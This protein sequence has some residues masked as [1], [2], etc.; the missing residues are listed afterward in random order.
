MMLL[1]VLCC[2]KAEELNFTILHTSDEHSSLMPA[3]LGDYL[4]GQPCPALGG[5]ARLAT[6]VSRIKEAKASE[7]VLLLSS[8]DFS[9]GTPF[10][11]LTLKGHATELELM[12]KTGYDATTPGNHEFDYGPNGL[13]DYL[14]RHRKLFPKPAILSS[15]IVIPEGHPLAKSDLKRH[16]VINLDN[17]LKIGIFAIL[18]K[19]AHRLAPTAAPLG[20]SDQHTAAHHEIAALKAAGADVIVALT[21]AGYYEDLELATKVAGIHLILGGHDHISLNP[22]ATA[23]KSIIMHSGSYLRSLG[24]LDLAFDR[25]SGKIR[26]RNQQT[27][28]PFLHA[29]DETIAENP[30]IAGN[31][32]QYFSELEQLTAS[33]TAGTISNLR[34]P[35]ARANFALTKHQQLCE[36]NVGNFLTDAIRFETGKITGRPV[37]F[38]IHANGIIRGDILPSTLAE[39]AG[40]ISFFDLIT[41]CGL[42]SGADN[43]PGYPLVSFYLTGTEI[44]N[45]LEV[46]TLLPILWN[47]VYFLQ[48]SG[49]RYRYDPDRAV[50]FWLPFINKPLPAYKSVLRAER[51]TGKGVQQGDEDEFVQ[52]IQGDSTLYHVATTHYMAS[53]LPMVGKKLPKLNLVLKDRHGKPVDLDQTILRISGREF[54]LWEAAVRYAGSFEKDSR[55]LPLIPDLYQHYGKRIIPAKGQSLWAWPGIIAVSLVFAALILFWRHRKARR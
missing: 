50:W 53:Y 55:G 52:I 37:D 38:A 3:P 42:G 2:A 4:P 35:V 29:I 24:Q 48:F 9:G 18:G 1:A 17:G 30:E 23:G 13:A 40:E 6:L 49:L 43:E 41:T 15:N 51:F 47:D 45:M 10:A 20:F 5:F 27:Q 46:A 14:A 7:P 19:G 28:N 32:E 25:D 31:I 11:W 8:G 26:L 16:L 21:H 36:T 34:Q 54:K 33:F 39:K 44:L 22:P 12:H